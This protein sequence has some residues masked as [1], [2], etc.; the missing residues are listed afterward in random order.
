MLTR[1]LAISILLSFA[2]LDSINAVTYYFEGTLSD[3]LGSYTTGTSFSGAFSYDYPQTEVYPGSNPHISYYIGK[4]LSFNIGNETLLYAN[5]SNR[6]NIY[7]ENK[8][9]SIWLNGVSTGGMPFDEFLYWQNDVNAGGGGYVGGKYISGFSLF[10][11]DSQGFAFADTSLVGDTMRL[12]DFDSAY[13]S[14]GYSDSPTPPGGIP[15]GSGGVRGSLTSFVP[16]PSAI[17][18]LAIGL[19]GLAILRRRRS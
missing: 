3:N 12:A 15:L 19:S 9:E 16:E 14:I 18:L 2:C 1:G 8:G 13:L 4:N 7:I 6:E 5:L 11:H 17:S 10:L